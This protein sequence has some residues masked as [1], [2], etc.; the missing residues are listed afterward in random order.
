MVSGKTFL[1][2]V[3]TISWLGKIKVYLVRTPIYYEAVE[4]VEPR[5]YKTKLSVVTSF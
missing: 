3:S 4:A 1:H 2:F 5:Y